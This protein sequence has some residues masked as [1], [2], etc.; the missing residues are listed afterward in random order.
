MPMAMADWQARLPEYGVGLLLTQ[1]HESP[2]SA[3]AC[4]PVGTASSTQST[5]FATFVVNVVP[6]PGF[7]L[8]ELPE[9]LVEVIPGPELVELPG[10]VFVVVIPGPELVVV[11]TTW[12]SDPLP[13]ASHVARPSYSVKLMPRTVA[14]SKPT[15]LAG[16]YRG[17]HWPVA[18]SA[19]M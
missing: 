19:P 8:V 6:N 10:P 4:A 15:A 11:V 2:P 7:E 12:A 13:A 16:T 9:P 17:T 1:F 18:G 3:P 5:K 14:P